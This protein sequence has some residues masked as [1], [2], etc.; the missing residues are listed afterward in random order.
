MSSWCKADNLLDNSLRTAGYHR[1]QGALGAPPAWWIWPQV[2]ACR[3]PLVGCRNL[4]EGEVSTSAA[5]QSCCRLK[6]QDASGQKGASKCLALLNKNSQV[7]MNS[8]SPSKHGSQS[9]EQVNLLCQLK[10]QSIN[11]KMQNLI[12]IACPVSPQWV[13]IQTI[14]LNISILHIK[15]LIL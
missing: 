9:S 2:P 4:R 15:P 3:P 12:Q 1:E 5:N 7:Q 11:Y 13:L 14:W 10:I 6:S 8:P